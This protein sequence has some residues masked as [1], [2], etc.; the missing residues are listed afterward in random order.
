MGDLSSSATEGS[1]SAIRVTETQKMIIDGS[2][3]PKDI[4]RSRPQF[5]TIECTFCLFVPPRRHVA[6]IPGRQ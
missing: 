5:E 6:D 4:R 1:G 3:D 2:V